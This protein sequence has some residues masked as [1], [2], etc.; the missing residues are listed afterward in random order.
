MKCV[1]LRT[2]NYDKELTNEEIEA[3]ISCLK[4]PSDFEFLGVFPADIK[5]IL[6]RVKK[7]YGVILNTH[8]KTKRGEHWVGIFINTVTKHIEYYDSYGK[9]PNK[10]ITQF[11]NSFSGYTVIYNTTVHQK[12]KTAC[13]LY[14]IRFIIL[15]ALKTPFKQ[16]MSNKITDMEALR[17]INMIAKSLR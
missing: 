9:L 1:K 10:L 12:G 11:I 14:A 15:K 13:G 8:P 3:F 17:L 2:I 7:Y 5:L 6:P 4:L 16:I